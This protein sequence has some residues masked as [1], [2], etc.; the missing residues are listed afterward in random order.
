MLLFSY[1]AVYPS[2]VHHVYLVREHYQHEEEIRP[3]AVRK[4][5]FDK[6]RP[7]I[8]VIRSVVG[9]QNKQYYR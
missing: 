8:R 2:S 5:I 4:D 9:G 3:L 7:G 1:T 6:V